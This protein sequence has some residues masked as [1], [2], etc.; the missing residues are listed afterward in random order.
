M[1]LPNR[2]DP[3]G[4]LHKSVSR[5]MFTG[6]RGCLVNEHGDFVRHHNGSLWI[7]CVLT[8]KDWKSPLSEPRHWTP[9]FFLDD[10]V[11][12]AAGHRP[13]GLCRRDDY[14]SY[15]EAVA[16]VLKRATPT[17]TDLNQ[18][19][20]SERHQPGKGW[21]RSTDR[22][23]WPTE[24]EDLPSGSVFK[25]DD[26]VPTLVNVGHFYRFSF[27]GWKPVAAPSETQVLV[28]TPPTSI[29]AL[30]NGFVPT[31]HESAGRQLKNGEN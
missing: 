20:A 11:S 19:L 25:G 23:L 14:V 18:M 29:G 27:A 22:R 13:C 24:I 26:G 16:A 28:I 21:S 3:Y 30:Q 7:A 15:K 5:G 1:S 2:V 9:L 10:A 17:A 4:D 6:N 31:L 8:Y 12:L